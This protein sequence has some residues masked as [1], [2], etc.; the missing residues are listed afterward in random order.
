MPHDHM[1]NIERR[2]DPHRAVVLAL[3][4]ASVLGAAG[5]LAAGITLGNP[6][7]L[8]AALASGLAAGILFGVAWAHSARAAMSQPS[9]S[10]AAPSPASDA[11]SHTGWRRARRGPRGPR[12]G[13]RRRAGA[14]RHGDRERRRVRRVRASARNAHSRAAIRRLWWTAIGIGLAFAAAGHRSAGRPLSRPRRS[15]TPSRIS[16]SRSGSA[17]TRLD[18]L[19]VG[20]RGGSRMGGLREERE[21][22][23]RSRADPPGMHRSSSSS[24]QGD[25]IARGR[26]G[27]SHGARGVLPARQPCEPAG[28]R[29]RHGPASA[30]RRPPLHLGAHGGSP[31]RRAAARRMRSPSDGSPRRSRWSDPRSR[32]SSSGSVFRWLQRCRRECIC[33]GRGRSTASRASPCCAF[34]PCRWVTKEK[35]WSRVPRTCSGRGS[36]VAPS[37]RCCSVTDA[38]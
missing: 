36:T 21:R 34:R 5:A 9:D 23:G 25:E 8:D 29:A 20:A 3:L 6:V 30:R 17:R 18:L 32:G 14:G 11:R 38:T 19:R 7:L 13:W 37:T 2:S 24:G 28:Q 4:G 16:G 1:S 27:L 22:P 15:T 26:N 31:E 35:K 33:T 10:T 12:C